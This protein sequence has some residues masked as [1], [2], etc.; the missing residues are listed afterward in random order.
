MSQNE[1]SIG[2]HDTLLFDHVETNI[3]NSYNGHTGAFIAPINGVYMFFYTVCGDRPSFMSIEITSTVLPVELY[4]LRIEQHP[5]LIQD[6][7]VLP[8]SLL[9]KVMTVL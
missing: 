6:A 7:R 3:G 1:L 4:M 2:P 5:A 9:T 8:Y